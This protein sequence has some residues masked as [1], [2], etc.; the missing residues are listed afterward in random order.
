MWHLATEWKMGQTVLKDDKLWTS[1]MHLPAYTS[2][3]IMLA[4]RKINI[5]F[6]KIWQ[7]TGCLAQVFTTDFILVSARGAQM[8]TNLV[9]QKQWAN[10]SWVGNP[11]RPLWLC[12]K[13]SQLGAFCP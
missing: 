2:Q 1:S 3:N 10:L 13:G 7:N 4:L 12:F 6:P 9:N 5:M 8:R 11:H